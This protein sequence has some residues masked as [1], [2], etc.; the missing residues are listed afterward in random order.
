MTGFIKS[1]W[2]ARNAFWLCAPCI[3]W[4]GIE[5]PRAARTR[6]FIRS[7]SL[8][9][10][11]SPIPLL[12]TVCRDEKQP[13]GTAKRSKIYMTSF[14]SPLYEIPSFTTFQKLWNFTPLIEV[15]GE[16]LASGDQ[17]TNDWKF[18]VLWKPS[19]LIGS[20]E[21]TRYLYVTR[22][23]ASQLFWHTQVL[24]QKSIF[25]EFWISFIS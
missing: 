16:K 13:H 15:Y 25:P 8:P 12:G 9:L 22:L 24:S 1:V 20:A 21:K 4:S 3:T 7:L 14:K 11:P 23:C 18:L 2:W 19:A 5:S 17:H 10:P 6:L